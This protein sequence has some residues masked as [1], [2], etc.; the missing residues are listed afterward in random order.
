M[1]RERE[2][3]ERERERTH[4]NIMVIAVYR[5]RDALLEVGNEQQ[6]YSLAPRNSFS[7]QLNGYPPC[8][9]AITFL[10]FSE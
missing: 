8:I 6:T 2:R 3:E 7:D 10:H 4:N 9:A 1:E 5:V